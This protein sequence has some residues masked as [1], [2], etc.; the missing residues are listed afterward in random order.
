MAEVQQWNGEVFLSDQ[1]LGTLDTPIIQGYVE[2]IFFEQ[3][4]PSRI[5]IRSILTER[6]TILDAHFRLTEY[7]YPRSKGMHVDGKYIDHY[8]TK[9]L[10]NEALRIKIVGAARQNTKIQIRWV[11]V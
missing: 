9:H 4:M 1:G 11:T 3:T 10:L 2:S 7:A 6:Y 8:A 5:T